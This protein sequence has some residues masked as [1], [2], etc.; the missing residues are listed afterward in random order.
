M[1][2]VRRRHWPSFLASLALIFCSIGCHDVL[3]P[4]QMPVATVD[5]KVTQRGIPITRGWVEFVPIDG[6]VGR[7]RSAPLRRDGTFH[8]TKVPVGLNLIRLVNVDYDP[9]VLGP[10]AH[11]LRRVFGAFTSPIRRTIALDRNPLLDV[12]IA[13][14][15]VKMTRQP[16]RPGREAPPNDGAAP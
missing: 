4:E 9:K 6:T 7:M 14:E 3:G 11:D 15:Y 8:A 13:E 16:G 10:M 1:K 5:G 2:P 12:E